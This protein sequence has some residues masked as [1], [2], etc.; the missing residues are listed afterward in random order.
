MSP[1]SDQAIVSF[2]GISKTFPGQ[3]VLYDVSLDMHAGQVH[4]LLGENGSG[5]STL[6]K[7]LSGYHLPDLGGRVLVAGE[8]LELGS[9]RASN[10]AGLRFV[11]QR[12]ALIPQLSAVDNVALQAGFARSHYID[13]QE[14][15]RETERLLARLGI[16]MDIW[17]PL[18]EC[19]AVE[20]TAVALAR[21][22]STRAGDLRV[23]VLDEPTSSLP[24]SEVR[25]LF[26][27][28]GQLRAEGVALMYVSHRLDEVFAIADRISV[29][30]DGR[31]RATEDRANV[32]QEKL[33]GWI[34]GRAMAASYE[35]PDRSSPA[36]GSSAPPA[37]QV[38][39]LSAGRLDGVSLSVRAGEIVGVTGIA[40]SG[41]EDL[42]RA[43]V[44]GLPVLG[45]EVIVR[46]EPVRP[47]NPHTAARSG[48]A[49]GLS[50][51]QGGSAVAQFT[52]RENVTLA[53]LGGIKKRASEGPAPEGEAELVNGWITRLDVRPR[54]PERLYSLLSGG[55]QQKTILARCLCTGASVLV[56]DDPTAGVDVGARRALYDLIA[57]EAG[58]GTAVVI[59]SSDTE[60]ILSVSDRAVVI[61]R[62]HVV[63][64]LQGEELTESNLIW[65]SAH[66]PG[67][68]AATIS[69][70]AR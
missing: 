14:Q 28:I 31:L 54:D 47:L 32:D 42:A 69:E 59:C 50:N 12:L 45:G 34:T 21:A 3:Q 23:I 44:G 20:R 67:V 29:L 49:L 41:R 38:S 11:H 64:E 39:G 10:A 2:E 16:E 61:H 5:K 53:G 36:A 40:G 9:P 60:D 26:E 27:L 15:A 37:L 7:I 66:G 43:L 70:V 30:R 4:A 62:G 1:Q 35:A 65:A 56:L 17:K 63:G 18:S 57:A 22:I 24:E 8:T 25:H 46:G 13:W 51:T 33:L 68:A 52:V 48:L 55:N 19:R 58:R 6:I